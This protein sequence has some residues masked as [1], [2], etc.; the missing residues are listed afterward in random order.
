[1]GWPVSRRVKSR[2]PPYGQGGYRRSSSILYYCSIPRLTG[3]DPGRPAKTRG[4]LM[5][6]M[7]GVVVVPV[8]HHISW[9]AARIG[10]SN[11]KAMG[12]DMLTGPVAAARAVVATG[13]WG[14]SKHDMYLIRGS[15]GT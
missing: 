7:Y 14:K 8:V 13:A 10:P 9:S 11:F 12:L 5:G 6:R 3:R 15:V 1:M 2:G 4:R